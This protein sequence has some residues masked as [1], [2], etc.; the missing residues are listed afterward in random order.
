MLPL[1]L[2]LLPLPPLA[3]L[4]VADLG[5]LDSVP[6]PCQ[7]LFLFPPALAISF[8]ASSP[9]LAVTLGSIRSLKSLVAPVAPEDSLG[10][11]ALC[12]PAS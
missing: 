8:T 4:V 2:A 10:V 11:T 1:L 12:G 3:L 6:C 7:R 9:R 5:N